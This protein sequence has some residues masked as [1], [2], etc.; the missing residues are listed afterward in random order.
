MDIDIYQQC[1]CHSSKKIKFCCGKD[2]VADLNQIVAKCNSNQ[3]LSALDQIERVI[4]RMG[5]KD[6]LLNLQTH[7]LFTM[8]E[9][10]KAEEANTKFV[11]R[12]PNHP[13]GRQHEALIALSKGDVIEAI[14]KLQDSIDLVQSD[15]IP[16]PLSNA[17]KLVGGVLLSAGHIV[18]ARAHLQFA[19]MIRGEGTE[20][21]N[22]MLAESFR[23]PNAPLILKNDFRLEPPPA[24]KEWTSKY[25][26]VLRTL[27]RGQFRLALKM[28]L[29]MNEH[30]P[31]QKE[32][33]YGIAVVN[34]M[35]ANETGMSDAWHQAA[36]S[37][38][39]PRWQAVEAESL[40]QIFL[41]SDPSGELDIVACECPVKDLDEV[42]NLLAADSRFESAP[43]PEQDPFA[44]GP[45]PRYAYYMLDREQIQA[46]DDLSAGDIPLV[47]GEWLLYGKQT[48]RDARMVLVATKNEF[49]ESSLQHV[50]DLIAGGLVDGQAKEEVVSSTSVAADTL[51]W[52]WRVPR[53]VSV[54]LHRKLIAEYRREIL[55]DRW[56]QIKF[57]CLNGKTPLE[58]K[59]DPELS[60]QLDALVLNLEQSTLLQLSGED[61]VQALREKLGLP[62][63]NAL[64]ASQHE[65]EVWT[66]L[67]LCQ[68]DP[69]SFSDDQL[70]EAYAESVTIGN[71]RVLKRIIPE[72]LQRETLDQIPRDICY[73]MLAQLTDDDSQ[74]IDYLQQA[75]QEAKNAGR[76]IGQLL[77]QE[78]EVRLTRGMTD[79]LPELLQTIQQKYMTEPNVEYQLM[80]VLSKFGLISPD[81]RTVS[82]PTRQ[83]AEPTTESES[84]IWTPDSDEPA[85]SSEGQPSKIWVPGSD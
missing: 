32:I 14:E 17:F 23:I 54:E 80:R 72:V 64:D 59:D 74:A 46:T 35:L 21:I 73:S 27:G 31:S 69:K 71:T 29:R 58:A 57:T 24:D 18:A 47:I 16:L 53:G 30:W 28:L 11:Q 10:G 68:F 83:P 2:I 63:E 13:V 40:S 75:R 36:L 65:D 26:T 51:A 3:S 22:A 43:T 5:E 34:S 7:I 55:L 20:E 39:M 60:I 70:F 33:V 62:V 19:L 50:K 8:G 66:P 77:V 25:E 41:D 4:A 48:D 1:P 37:P 52:N 45:A 67:R 78:F 42:F 84:K 79:K 44:Q 82:L 61:D 85:L 76:S 6:C 15:E 38:E 9:I 81:G 49:L 56:P 12:N